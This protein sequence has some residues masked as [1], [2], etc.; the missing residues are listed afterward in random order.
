MSDLALRYGINPHQVP[1]SVVDNGRALPFSVL[2][3]ALGYINLLD[4]LN[5]WQLVKELRTALGLPA[6]ASFKH[7]SPAGAAVYVPLTAET[8][9][10]YHLDGV[11]LSE[12]A[13]AYARARG[14]DRVASFGDFV[15]LS[16]PVDVA[17]AHLL[18]REV[19]D[20]VIAPGYEPQ[21]LD[22]LRAKKNGSYIVIAIDA[23]YVPPTVERR[24]VYGITL[25]QR[26]ND[27]QITTGLLSNIVTTNREL[28][29]AARRD[30]IVAMVT[31][32]FTQS[33]SVCLAVDGQTIGVGAGQQSR[34]LCTRL[35]SQKAANWHLRQ[36][37][38][39]HH[40]N[41][42][43]KLSRTE[44]DNAID[45]YL[46]GEETENWTQNFRE[47]PLALSLGEIQLWTSTLSGVSLGSDG[48]IP[49]RDNI[50]CAARHGVRYVA[51]PGGSNRDA[52]VVE[53]CNDYDMVMVFTGVR[54]F[55]HS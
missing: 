41:F 15:A 6:A 25:E 10:A 46:S 8:S 37:S 55:H 27:A 33:N 36:S 5:A 12:L 20:G 13:T 21:A 14:C 17:T 47:A 31:L 54:L 51:Q 23:D 4:A 42:R 35:A 29:E 49:F 3:G 44:V 50:D 16:D 2:N 9:H 22:I 19:S 28:T 26:R 45:Q 48:F 24:D 18:R 53:A 30:L 43:D 34:I 38:A 1:A 32:K 39:V 40:L 52:Q 7:V 11:E